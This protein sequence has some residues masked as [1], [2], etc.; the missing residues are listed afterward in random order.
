VSWISFIA[1]NVLG[2]QAWLLT[3]ILSTRVIFIFSRLHVAASITWL[4]FLTA[5]LVLHQQWI[6][7]AVR[8]YLP[9][10]LAANAKVNLEGQR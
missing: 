5:H 1:S 8:R 10:G 4:V 7:S 9:I 2:L 3:A 6:A